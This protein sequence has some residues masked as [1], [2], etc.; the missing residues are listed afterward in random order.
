MSHAPFTIDAA[1][2]YIATH[3]AQVNPTYRPEFHFSAEVGWINDPNGLV[4]FRGAYHLFYQ[5]YPYGSQWGPMHWGHAKTTDFVHWEH[6]PVALAPDQPY[7]QGGCFSGSAL[8]VGDTLWLMYTGNIT[9]EQGRPRQVQN[10]AKSSDGIHFEKIAQNPVLDEKDLPDSLLPSDFRDPKIFERKGRYYAVVAAK[11]VDET[12]A[13]VLVGSDNLVDWQFES[14]FLKGQ[15]DQGIMW[16]CPDYFELDGQDYL[17]LSPMQ[18]PKQA[19]DYRNLNS[20][21][22]MTGQVDW[23]SKSFQLEKVK[24]LDHGHDFYAT[25]SLLDAQGRRLMIA[26]MQTWGRNI[27]T[28]ELGHH[29]AGVMSLPRLLTAQSGHLIQTLPE[30]LLAHLPEIAPDLEGGQTVGQ[31]EVVVTGDLHYQ[32]GDA[33]D[34]ISFGY[35]ATQQEV[36]IDRASLA[37]KIKGEE[38]WSVDRRAVQ[39]TAQHLRIVLDKQSI[40]IFVNHG[41]ESLTST[42]YLK[43]SRELRHLD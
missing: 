28:H 12:G 34:Y 8:V 22:V 13:V 18:Y 6:L 17:V 3:K 24:E 29:W 20:T 42:Y 11:H 35:D 36:Y 2:A 16:E 4:Y 32:L 37:L 1:Q 5:F 23:E 39:V 10:M 26:W 27:P 40:E 14:I 41:Q 31:F 21:V 38:A 15:P 7:D 33:D 9:D 30:E 19:L 25:Q 43:G